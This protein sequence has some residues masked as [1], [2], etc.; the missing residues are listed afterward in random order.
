MDALLLE[1]D[2]VERTELTSLAS[3]QSA[4]PRTVFNSRAAKGSVKV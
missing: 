2:D 1:L 4:A 3:S